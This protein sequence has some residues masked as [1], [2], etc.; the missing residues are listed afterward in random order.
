MSVSHKHSVRLWRGRR[1]GQKNLLKI[2]FLSPVWESLSKAE[3][4]S[5]TWVGCAGWCRCKDYVTQSCGPKS[6]SSLA[7][8]A[9][10]YALTALFST[11]S[12]KPPNG[13]Y[14]Y[15]NEPSTINAT[16]KT[17]RGV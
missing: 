8:A 2:V 4:I 13:G 3:Y 16:M 6:F 1:K 17:L 11:N 15:K 9:L 5:Q 14:F 12:Q 10:H 7:R